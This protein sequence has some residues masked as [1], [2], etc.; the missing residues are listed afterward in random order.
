MTHLRRVLAPVTIV[1]LTCQTGAVALAPVAL[2]I[3]AADPHA[4]EC[5]C[6]HGPGA[7]C[8]M[9]HK[10]GGGSAPCAIQAA[11]G[12]G[13]AVLTTLVGTAGLLTEPAHSIQPPST[14]EHLRATDVHVVGELPVPPDPPPPR[15]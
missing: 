5:T 7:M 12:G 8:P 11:D 3:T 10:P 6:G 1:W 2:W 13:T 14:T 15:A 4:T 9:H